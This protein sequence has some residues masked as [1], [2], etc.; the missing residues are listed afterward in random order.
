MKG[1][2]AENPAVIQVVRAAIGT[3]PWGWR[4]LSSK[5]DVTAM[6]S[7]GMSTWQSQRA[8]QDDSQVLGDHQVEA[9]QVITG[10]IIYPKK[11]FP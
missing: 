3:G 2:L 1:A 6:Q 10:Q 11:T 4:R 7:R 8:V 5:T 9:D